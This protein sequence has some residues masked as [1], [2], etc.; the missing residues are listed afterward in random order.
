VILQ[1]LHAAITGG[2]TGI[3]AAIARALSAEGARVTLIGRRRQPLAAMADEVG[4][5]AEVADASDEAALRAALD[6]ARGRHGPVA[7]AIANAG[8]ALTAPFAR[9][10]AGQW[11]AML[12]ANLD[13]TANLARLTLD[14]LKSAPQ[15]RFVAVASTAALTGYAYCT[16]YAAA[17][18]A[19]LGLVRSLALE[20]AGT[21]VTVNAVCPGFTDTAIAGEAM[22]NIA[23][24]TGRSADEARAELARFNPQG[25]LV[26]PD[27]VA[28]AVAWLCAPGSASVTGQAIAI[29]G[30][31]TM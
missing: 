3:G 2:G 29:S 20:L 12:S 16:A 15:G 4:G 7:I 19:V 30:G 31:E 22:T 26:M 5:L 8:S 11:Q 18:H 24:K 13:T 23:A 27:E 25:R 1:G 9:T 28:A 6:A 10:D 14:D 17:K 21:Q